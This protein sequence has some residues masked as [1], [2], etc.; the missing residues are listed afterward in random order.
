MTAEASDILAMTVWNF[1]HDS[2]LRA[3]K[4]GVRKKKVT[5]PVQTW[6]EWYRTDVAQVSSNIYQWCASK[7]LN[8]HAG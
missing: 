1:L 2:V 8:V 5:L 4:G 3:S 6:L 7:P